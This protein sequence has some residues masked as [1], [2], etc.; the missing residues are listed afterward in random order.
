MAHLEED[1][2]DVKDPESDDPGGIEGVTKEF[3]VGLARAVKDAQTD[4]KCCYYC[5]S[6][7]HFIYNCLPVKISRDRK[8]VK[9]EGGDGINEGNLDP[10]DNNKCCKEP[11]DGGSRGVKTTPQTPFLNPDPFQ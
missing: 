2:G 6:L 7:E 3:M 10:S 8:T 4:E 11:P 1:A 9:W 5:S